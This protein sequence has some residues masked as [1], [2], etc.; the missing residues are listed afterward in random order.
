M[1]TSSSWKRSES[2][3]FLPGD[4]GW[5]SP[6]EWGELNKT[7]GG[8]LIAAVPL[9]AVCH[10]PGLCRFESPKSHDFQIGIRG[11]KYCLKR[12]RETFSL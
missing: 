3:R 10:T 1:G 9:A 4:Q 2:C 11:L 12:D 7:I 5:P 8:R 6:Q